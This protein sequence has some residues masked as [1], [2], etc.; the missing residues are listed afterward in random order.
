M[1]VW[2]LIVWL[3]IGGAVGYL[4]PRMLG[5]SA[6]GGLIGDLALAVI[7]A[8]GGAYGLLLSGLVGGATIG[9]MI[10]SLV[11]AAVGAFALVWVVRLFGKTA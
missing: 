9:S 6:P 8:V 1:P 10:V 4:A 11:G 2:V 7:G 3:I 5:G